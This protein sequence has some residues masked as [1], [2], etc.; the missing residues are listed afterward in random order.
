MPSTSKSNKRKARKVKNV[1]KQKKQCHE[2]RNWLD[3]PSDVMGNIL[4]RIGSCDI[5]E[6]AQKVCT[7]WRNICKDPAMWRVIYMDYFNSWR[8]THYQL[9]KMCKN[10]VDRSQGQL[11]DITIIGFVNE[12]LIQY[13]ADRYVIKLIVTDCFVH[14]CLLYNTQRCSELLLY[15]SHGA[16]LICVH[17]I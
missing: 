14:L 11:V 3:L 1:P 12:D 9:Q 15:P 13:V 2:T 8:S 4:C 5:L 10:A 6:N 16:T 17:F 7:I